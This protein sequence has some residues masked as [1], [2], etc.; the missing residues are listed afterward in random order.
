MMENRIQ[1]VLDN[2]NF[3]KVKKVMDLLN[4]E[5]YHPETGSNYIP[6]IADLYNTAKNYLTRVVKTKGMIE[7]GGFRAEY[8]DDYLILSFVVEQWDSEGSEE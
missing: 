2:F 3:H 1:E 5:W 8:F 4:W 7:S 6:S